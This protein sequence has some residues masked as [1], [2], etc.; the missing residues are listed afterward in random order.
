MSQKHAP[1][2]A[3]KYKEDQAPVASQK[4]VS[5]LCF[6][7]PRPRPL[8]LASP[9][10]SRCTARLALRLRPVCRPLHLH[11]RATSRLPLLS[12]PLAS[13]AFLLHVAAAS[14]SRVHHR[15]VTPAAA[16][17]CLHGM[18]FPPSSP[19]AH[20]PSPCPPVSCP[21]APRALLARVQSAASCYHR[22]A[23][24]SLPT[25]WA[26]TP[27]AGPPS[28]LSTSQISRCLP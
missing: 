24:G 18:P 23:A 26:S 3:R 5:E 25:P 13:S 27:T 16:P 17:L 20:A 22:A 4:M 15:P 2:R 21:V 28:V 1:D 14:A 7:V 9:S 12:P 11:L 6:P 10:P 19:A 8:P